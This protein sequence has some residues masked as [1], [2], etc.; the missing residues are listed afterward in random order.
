VLE[1]SRVS[2]DAAAG[3]GDAPPPQPRA[4]P[5][6]VADKLRGDFGQLAERPL[7]AVRHCLVGAAVGVLA[8]AL[9]IGDAPVMI[10]YLAQA[11]FS[12]KEAIGTTMAALVPMY[13]LASAMHVAKGNT[14]NALLPV[15]AI[16]C[17]VGSACGARFSSHS[18]QEEHLKL[19]FAAF[20]LVL[21]V[22]TGRGAIASGALGRFGRAG[23][24]S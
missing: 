15:M 16:G 3:R 5:P 12:Q 23:A 24:T 4:E 17:G 8:G 2:A 9:A 22:L 14:V 19:C 7:V 20:V 18:L 13:V 1:R 10:A 11:G 21:G 6:S